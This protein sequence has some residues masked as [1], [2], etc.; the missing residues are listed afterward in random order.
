MFSMPCLSLVWDLVVPERWGISDW[1][2]ALTP[3]DPTMTRPGLLDRLASM[4]SHAGWNWRGIGWSRLGSRRDAPR[5][6]RASRRE[7]VGRDRT[8]GDWLTRLDAGRWP[9]VIDRLAI[10]SAGWGPRSRIVPPR[11]AAATNSLQ[12]LGLTVVPV[13]HA[14]LMTTPERVPADLANLPEWSSAVRDA[15]AWGSDA[16]DRFQTVTRWR[17]D[18]MPR[19]AGSDPFDS[20]GPGPRRSVSRFYG[21]FRAGPRPGS[22]SASSIASARRLPCG[23]SAGPC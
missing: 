18:A 5:S 8:S 16:S 14:L 22:R 23:W 1:G 11:A 9:I 21:R 12:S 15:G 3:A 19:L 2:D 10:A 4:P 13:G 20:T 17:E 6:S 7:P